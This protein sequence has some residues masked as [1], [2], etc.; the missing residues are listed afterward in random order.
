MIAPS[1]VLD[2]AMRPVLHFAKYF[3]DNKREN[4]VAYPDNNIYKYPIGNSTL[5]SV[6][7]AL[8]KTAT[9]TPDKVRTALINVIYDIVVF[10]AK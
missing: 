3:F 5:S 7:S 2:K 6:N 4:E 10:K 1:V 9:T 8:N